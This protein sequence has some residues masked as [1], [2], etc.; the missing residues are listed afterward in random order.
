MK[1]NLTKLTAAVTVFT[2]I[3]WPALA[4]N[5]DGQLQCH[6]GAVDGGPL[7]ILCDTPPDQYWGTAGTMSTDAYVGD[8]VDG[9]PYV[10][11]GD[12][13]SSRNAKCKWTRVAFAC[14]Q[15]GPNPLQCNNCETD[16][17]EYYPIGDCYGYND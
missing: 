4:C 17:T 8:C 2:T 3:A 6:T 11:G 13:C 7:P 1:R 5:V 14:G 9:G 10:D 15:I 16:A 12:G